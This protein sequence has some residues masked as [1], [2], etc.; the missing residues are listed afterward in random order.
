MLNTLSF[1]IV[2]PAK[3]TNRLWSLLLMQLAC[4]CRVMDDYLTTAACGCENVGHFQSPWCTKTL[5]YLDFSWTW[6][7]DCFISWLLEDVTGKW[8][9]GRKTIPWK[10]CNDD[11]CDVL[12]QTVH[13]SPCRLVQNKN[14][15]V[16][17]WA[18]HTNLPFFNPNFFGLKRICVVI[19]V[20]FFTGFPCKLIPFTLFSLHCK[21]S[22][23]VFGGCVGETCILY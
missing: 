10:C 21:K 18:L 14:S 15:A 19:E 6:S 7:Y 5:F 17:N 20:Q 1:L 4:S 11:A 16:Q 9:G 23:K 3:Q 12:D 13:Q 8:Q 22:F 2:L